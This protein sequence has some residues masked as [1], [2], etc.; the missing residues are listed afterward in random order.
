M[1]MR[2]VAEDVRSIEQAEGD[3]LVAHILAIVRPPLIET[4][5]R[6]RL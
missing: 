5:S 3:W 2:P 6:M 4:G 1:I